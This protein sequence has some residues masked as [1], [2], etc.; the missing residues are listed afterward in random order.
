VRFDSKTGSNDSVVYYIN[1]VKGNLISVDPDNIA[2]IT[3]LKGDRV[4]D[5]P[6]FINQDDVRN[7]GVVVVVTKDSPEG[8]VY[9]KKL[10]NTS[11]TGTVLLTGSLNYKPL[12]KN[13]SSRP[14]RSVRPLKISPDNAVTNGTTTAIDTTAKT[15]LKARIIRISSSSSV[16]VDGKNTSSQNISV[17]NDKGMHIAFDKDKTPLIIIDGKEVPAADINKLNPSAIESMTVSN[18]EGTLKKYGSKAKN[19]VVQLTTKK[20]TD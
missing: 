13:S 1:G 3:V 8:K 16:T 2:K 14:L 15:P 9:M 5:L 11:N 12:P 6:P 18:D 10:D 17:D 20:K 7:A 19:G 4:S